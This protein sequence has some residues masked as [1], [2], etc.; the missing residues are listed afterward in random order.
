MI[1]SALLPRADDQAA[2]DPVDLGRIAEVEVW[3]I[4]RVVGVRKRVDEVPGVVVGFLVDP[5]DV[6]VG[7]VD[8]QR[9]SLVVVAGSV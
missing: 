2:V 6:T 3:R 7:S 5:L 4:V 1:E 8:G 9:A